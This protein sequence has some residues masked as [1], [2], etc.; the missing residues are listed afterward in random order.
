MYQPELLYMTLR[1]TSKKR[2]RGIIVM[3]TPG[4]LGSAPDDEYYLEYQ[5]RGNPTVVR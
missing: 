3:F 5:V 1:E 2:T 4:A